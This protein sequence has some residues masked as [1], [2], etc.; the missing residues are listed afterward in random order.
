[1]FVRV[2]I[3]IPSDKTFIYAVPKAFEMDIATGKRVF[4]PLEKRSLTGYITE[5]MTASTCEKIKDITDILDSEPLFNEDDLIFYQWISWYYIYPLGKTLSEILPGGIDL[6]SNRWIIPAQLK[7]DNNTIKSAFHNKIMDL[8]AE[9]PNGLPLNRIKTILGKKDIYGDIKALRS[10]GLIHVQDRIEKPVVPQKKEKIATVCFGDISSIKLTLNQMK[11]IDF[12]RSHGRASFTTLRE[13]FTNAL[14]LTKGLEKK[15]LVHISEEDMYRPAG[16]PPVIGKDDGIIIPN[17]EQEIALREIVKGIESQRFSPYLLH[18]VTGSGK[19]EVYL[20]AIEEALRLMGGAIFLVPEIALTPQLLTRLNGRFQDR[21]IA[22][23]HSGISKS[24]RYDQW[25]RIQRGDIS[26]VVGARSALFAPVRNLKLIIV[27]EEHDASYKQDDRIR[28]NA[29]DLAVMRAKLLSATVVIGSATPAIQTYFNT[30]KG[31]YTYL[32]LSGRV[33]GRPMPEVEIV[34]MKK[35]KEGGSMASIPILSR[36]LKSAIQ[37]TL[38]KKQQALLF[39]NRRGFHTFMFCPDCGYVFKCLNCAVSMTHHAAAGI[40]KCHH[41]DYRIRMPSLCPKCRS[42]RIMQHGV[43]TQRLEEEI[44]RIFPGA[45]VGRMDSDT[46][47]V[48]GSSIKI[49]QSLDRHEIDIL[50]G[51]QMITKGH[52]FHNVTLVGIIS[53]DTSLNLPDFRAA[54]RTFQILTQASG[55]GGRGDFPG[56]VIIQTF[57]PGHYAIVRAKKHDYIGFYGEELSLRKDLSYPPYSRIVNLHLSG[58][59]QNAAMEGIEKLKIL[60][61]ELIKADKQRGGKVD[62]IG[63]A[64]APIF[65]IKGRYR[66]QLLLKGKDTQALNRLS[67]DILSK[68]A[69]I[70]LDI[71]VD[72]DPINF[73]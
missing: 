11:L 73:M 34:D 33:K 6:K 39:L 21:E 31:K 4:V 42:N 1:M 48:K 12:L 15:G 22:V 54:E 20:N 28:Y 38:E 9:F 32:V 2:A 61:D 67:R 72:V 17:E 18:G 69:G 58:T 26:I 60:A 40:L 53:A 50:V 49:L 47:A 56:R 43:G 16:N 66:W 5:I 51:T 37:D 35:E 30:M 70:G 23:L 14:A 71:K 10:M 19:T 44:K 41:C 63:P 29:R 27:D 57:N 59:R 24:V 25:R 46:T 3:N 36:V 7:G 52:D 62:I 55:R 8:L 65:R 64:E 13:T 68:T 45:R